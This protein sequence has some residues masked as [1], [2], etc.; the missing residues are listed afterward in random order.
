M[1][2]LLVISPSLWQCCQNNNVTFSTTGLSFNSGDSSDDSALV[3][4]MASVVVVVVFPHS[5]TT[6]SYYMRLLQQQSC[7]RAAAC[8]FTWFR[9]GN[10]VLL[11]AIER[12]FFKSRKP[13]SRGSRTPSSSSCCC[14]STLLLP[15]RILEMHVFMILYCHGKAER[16]RRSKPAAAAAETLVHTVAK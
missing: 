3:A 16:R 9:I 1:S 4:H 6:T 12:I 8:I 15:S 10:D 14:C 11:L 5:D 13:E 2:T 7:L